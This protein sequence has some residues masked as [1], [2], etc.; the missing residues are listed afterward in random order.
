MIDPT[1]LTAPGAGSGRRDQSRGD[2]GGFTEHLA[3]I[4]SEI[5]GRPVDG[6]AVEAWMAGD[7]IPGLPPFSELAQR[8][9][10]EPERA[11]SA[12]PEVAA[13]AERVLSAT[14][15]PEAAPEALRLDVAA[16]VQALALSAGGGSAGESRRAAELLD[17]LP[18]GAGRRIL[19]ALPRPAPPQSTPD[20]EFSTIMQASASTTASPVRG[21]APPMPAV[22]MPP[23]QPGFGA[24]V[25][26]RIVWMAR[27]DT[28]EARLQ[29]N[30][31]ELGPL[32]VKLSV[33]GDQTQV[34]LAAHHAITREAMLAELPRLRQMLEDSG[35]TEVE[36]DVAPQQG[37]DSGASATG[38]GSGQGEQGA[39]GGDGDAGDGA[40]ESVVTGRERAGLV[41]HYA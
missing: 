13:L 20:V 14:P 33:R 4:L 34:T 2:A 35:F 3:G 15:V 1:M 38:Q 28:Q 30:P 16:F 40:V 32:E 27:H 22:P 5:A 41:D 11:R 6:D 36:V 37:E 31:P 39:A 18:P 29:L 23:G 12:D 8:L 26:E 10:A 21:E 25:G 24:A 7:A 19:D 9:A 17:E